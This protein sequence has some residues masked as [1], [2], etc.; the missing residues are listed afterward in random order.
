MYAWL[1]SNA[2]YTRSLHSGQKTCSGTGDVSLYLE[3]LLQEGGISSTW[4][5]RRFRHLL[6][7]NTFSFTYFMNMIPGCSLGFSLAPQKHPCK[8]RTR[9]HGQLHIMSHNAPG[10]SVQKNIWGWNKIPLSY[11]CKNQKLP[12]AVCKRWER[13]TGDDTLWK[14]LDL[15]L[16]AVPAGACWV[17]MHIITIVL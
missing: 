6:L 7:M 17:I 12:A 9:C 2:K 8:M 13:L 10:L 3:K 1:K 16:A 15:G 5:Q 11:W 14:R 4:C